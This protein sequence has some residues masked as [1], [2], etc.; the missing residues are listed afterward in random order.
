MKII[1]FK[2]D[3]ELLERIDMLAQE[4]GTNRSDIIRKAII[5]YLSKAEK[6][7][8]VKKPRIKIIED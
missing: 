8:A 5:M 3:E 6:E 1:T 4:S 2:L 7:S